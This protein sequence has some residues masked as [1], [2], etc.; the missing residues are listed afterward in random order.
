MNRIERKKERSEEEGRREEKK[1]VE[2]HEE[3]EILY[4]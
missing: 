2:G 4:V 1:G 3:R